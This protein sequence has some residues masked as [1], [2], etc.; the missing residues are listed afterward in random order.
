MRALTTLKG[1]AAALLTAGLLSLSFT[2]AAAEEGAEGSAGAAM[3][4]LL[5]EPE[6]G[7]YVMRPTLPPTSPVRPEVGCI[8]SASR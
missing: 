7:C 1:F 2:A 3:N 5:K 6:I 4:Q 8:T